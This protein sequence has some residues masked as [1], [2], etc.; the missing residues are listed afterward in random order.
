MSVDWTVF[1]TYAAPVLALFVGAALDRYL[2][3]RPKL[4]SYIAHSS[5][6]K[7]QPPTG[8]AFQVHTHS[9][10]VRN[11]GR[12]SATNVRLGHNFL[13]PS[14]SV[15]PSVPYDVTDLPGDGK[16]LIFPAL[17]PGEQVTVAYLY[18]PPLLWSAIHSYT[19]SDEG[20]AKIVNV[21]PTPL[22]AP[23]LRRTWLAFVILGAITGLYIL[24]QL[25]FNLWRLVHSV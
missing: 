4:L 13:P 24:G 16:E 8:E 23:W 25:V 17:V 15:Y 14:F 21:L 9:V 22:P 6:V 20:F 2:E 10:V 11:A 19:K 3:R 1:A 12:R 5:A 7:V 18:Y